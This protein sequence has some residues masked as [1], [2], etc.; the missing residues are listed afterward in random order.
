[1]KVNTINALEGN[2]KGYPCK[3]CNN[4]GYIAVLGEDDRFFTRECSCMPMR[5]CIRQMESSGLSKNIK[6]LTFDAYEAKAPWQLALKS[7]VMEY[8]K[9]PQ[10][11]LMIGGQSGSGKTHLCTAVCRELLLRGEALMYMPWREYIG[12]LKALSMD[13]RERAELLDKCKNSPWLYIDDLYKTGR[14]QE[15]STHPTS[16]DINLAFEILNHR[17]CQDLPTIISSEKTPQE[18]VAIDEAMGSRIIQMC[19]KFVY[20]ITPDPGKNYRMRNIAS[21]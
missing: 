14:N 12:R 15:N 16:A 3:K 4:K 20:C 5:R 17:Y 1:M 19:G 18:L 8:A 7:A 21:Y 13:A 10:G 9:A 6:D 2:Y 11:W